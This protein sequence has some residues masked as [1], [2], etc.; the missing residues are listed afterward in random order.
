MTRQSESVTLQDMN[1]LERRI[2]D[3]AL[4]VDDEGNIISRRPDGTFVPIGHTGNT[5][6]NRRIVY[7]EE[8]AEH[9]ISVQ[10]QRVAWR[11]HHGYWPPEDM[12]V[13]MLDGNKANFRRDNL[14]LVPS[15][16]ERRAEVVI[17][18]PKR[19]PKK[20]KAVRHGTLP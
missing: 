13:M 3:G 15:G 5:R 1:A 8:G 2:Q 18:G 11:I 19:A 7:R 14:M 12:S 16:R 9:P 10:A 6:G 4:K 17:H 20:G